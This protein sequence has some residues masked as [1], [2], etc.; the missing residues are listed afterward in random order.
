MTAPV[1]SMASQ[2]DSCKL[3]VVQVLPKLKDDFRSS[4][5]GKSQFRRLSS[6]IEPYLQEISVYL[7]L[8][9]CYIVCVHIAPDLQ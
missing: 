9:Y 2:K 3:W 1:Q 7:C 5:G 8:I 6:H 4:A